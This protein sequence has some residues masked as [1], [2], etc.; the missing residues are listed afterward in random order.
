MRYSALI[1]IAVAT[2]AVSIHGCRAE[3]KPGSF[4][5]A[6]TE[7]KTRAK[8]STLTVADARRVDG[9]LREAG[10][11][12]SE[13]EIRYRAVAAAIVES[14]NATW[15][16]EFRCSKADST[17]GSFQLEAV[18]HF[19]SAHPGTFF[20]NV[21]QNDDFSP[22]LNNPELAFSTKAEA[23]VCVDN[24]TAYIEVAKDEKRR[25]FAHEWLASLQALLQEYTTDSEYD[26]RSQFG[27]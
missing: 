25:R 5:T 2:A 13:R 3:S 7:A 9:Y 11:G 12:D 22:E 4:Q 15:L 20:T 17:L 6:L 23:R 16:I 19:V 1:G 27:P 10:I 8:S 18:W 14:G 24:I 21:D 26:E